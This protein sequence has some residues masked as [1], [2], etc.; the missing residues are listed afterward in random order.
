[1]EAVPCKHADTKDCGKTCEC[2]CDGCQEYY[3]QLWEKYTEKCNLCHDCGMPRAMTLASLDNYREWHFFQP[4]EG[5]KPSYV[6]FMC[7]QRL[8]VACQGPL[9]PYGICRGCDCTGELH[10]C[11]CRQC[12]AKRAEKK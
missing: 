4:C 1:M 9:L 7:E 8:C 10:T 2:T 3:E 11:E 6:A 5:C 12:E